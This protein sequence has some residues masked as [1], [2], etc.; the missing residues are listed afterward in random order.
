MKVNDEPDHIIEERRHI[1]LTEYELDY[2]I[3]GVKKQAMDEIYADI[4]KGLVKRVLWI[5][6]AIGTA[7]TGWLTYKGVNIK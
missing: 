7:I 4:G 5:L 3:K 2:I 6:G 1:R